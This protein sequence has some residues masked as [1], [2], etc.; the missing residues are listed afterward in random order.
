MIKKQNKYSLNLFILSFSI[1]L[2]IFGCIIYL[3]IIDED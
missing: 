2:F 1:D 3:L